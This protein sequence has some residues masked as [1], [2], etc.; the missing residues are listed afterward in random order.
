MVSTTCP[1][2]LVMLPPTLKVNDWLDQESAGAGLARPPPIFSQTFHSRSMLQWCTQNTGSRP[3][4]GT[5]PMSPPI[6]PCTVPC[7]LPSR[8]LENPGDGGGLK[9]VLLAPNA[10]C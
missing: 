6:S 7:G 9:L 2:V 8:L 10:A 5:E 1:A 3:A 4:V